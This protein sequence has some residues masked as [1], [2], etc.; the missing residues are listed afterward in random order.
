MIIPGNGCSPVQ[1]ANWYSWLATSLAPILPDFDIILKDMPDP[2]E[3]KEVYWL[4]FIEENIKSYGKKYLVGHSSGTEAIMRY[5]E[6]NQVDGAFL[7][8]GC[9]S[10]LGSVHERISGYYPQQMDGSVREWRW[11]LMKKNC[12]FIVH[13]GAED[14]QFIPI[15]EMREIRDKLE[16]GKEFYFEF[17]KEKGF[18]HFMRKKF[19]ELLEIVKGKLALKENKP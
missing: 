18:G 10:D 16:L 2:L 4:P 6:K 12:G 14:D 19:P 1:R 3:A 7:V 17:G 11:D 9:V 13:V 15:L 5:I 8:S